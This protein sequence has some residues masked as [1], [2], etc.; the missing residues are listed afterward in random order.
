MPRQPI[1]RAPIMDDVARLAGVSHQTVS[2]VLNN[3]PSVR[4]ATRQRVFNAVDQLNYHRNALARGLA[5]RRSN[6]IGVVSFDTIL[7]GPAATLLGVERAARQAGYGINI[8]ALERLDRAGVAE[9][10]NRLTEQAVAGIV[11]IAPL[12][13]AA[14]HALS[15]SVPAIVVESNTTGPLPTV[16]VDQVAGARMA[17]EHLLSLGHDTVH[18]VSG[19]PDW[20]QA[21][22]RVEG[23]RQ[24]LEDAGRRVPRVIA[25]DWSPAAGYE[26]GRRLA[27]SPDATAVFCGNDQ[28][29]L[30]LLRALHERG[31]QVP[32]DISVVGFD[33]IPEAQHM[34]PP[35]TTVR[36]DFDEVGRRCL[37]VILDM[38][39]P[40]TATPR[41]QRVRPSL[42][43]R[44]SSSA[45]RTL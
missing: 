4:E 24:A 29:A 36:Q 32:E 45:Q 26:A 9:A 18:H 22:D 11:I 21:R 33:D 37:A 35:L 10:V 12:M 31:I 43:I 38:F 14:A 30:G 6:I 19:P 23:W 17:V 34:S 5:R 2:R 44:A 27:E 3:H 7:Y 41:H 42:A 40:D 28:Q 15:T 20:A 16:S 25:G 1:P 13:T 39:D 8:V